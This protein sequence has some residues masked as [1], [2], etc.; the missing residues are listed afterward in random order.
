MPVCPDCQKNHP[1]GTRICVECGIDLLTGQTLSTRAPDAT[2]LHALENAP[3]DDDRPPPSFGFRLMQFF[4]DNTPGLFIPKVFAGVVAVMLVA[5]AITAIAVMVF[6]VGLVGH[7]MLFAGFALMVYWQALAMLLTGQYTL[8]QN[9]MSDFRA[10]QWYLFA[11]LGFTPIAGVY[12]I[13]MVVKRLYGE[14]G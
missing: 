7:S 13:A 12:I 6:L 5:A 14:G 8:L 10:A 9:A 1:R 2:E 11:F 3:L 4:G